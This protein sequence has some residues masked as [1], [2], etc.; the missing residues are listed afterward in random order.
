MTATP[1]RPWLLLIILVLLAQLVGCAATP[2]LRSYEEPPMHTLA[3][4]DDEVIAHVDDP[5]ERFNR[6]MY[7]FNYRLDQFIFLPVVDAYETVTPRF[8]RT[9][10]SNFF[11][12]LG[13]VTSLGNSL[14]QLKGERAMRTTA[15]LLFNTLLGV[16]GLWDPATAMGLPREREDFGQTL[17][18]YGVPAGAYLV[19]PLFGPSNL[20]DTTGL[21]ADTVAANNINYLNV[22]ESSSEHPEIQVLDAIN[23]RYVTPFKYGQLNTPF[24]YS[25]VR[26]LYG[27]V[28]KLQV[29]D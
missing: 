27:E 16:G 29:A 18:H 4:F 26:Y 24:E 22:A 25:R 13:D 23:T 17:G 28:R 8:V 2:P 11:S 15:R 14:L 3:E 9:G 10:V 5:W 19:L 20:R 21:V 1:L 12:N 6:R 7:T